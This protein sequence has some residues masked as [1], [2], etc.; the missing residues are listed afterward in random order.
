M[1]SGTTMDNRRREMFLGY[2]K[3]ELRTRSPRL[4]GWTIYRNGSDAVV[5]H[6]AKE[7]AHAEDAWRDGQ[8]VLE[9]FEA[10]RANDLSRAA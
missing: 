7:F 1:K 10:N 8:R 2:V 4:W 5:R 9:G 3:V 6:S